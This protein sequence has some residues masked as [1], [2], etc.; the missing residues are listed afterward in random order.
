MDDI[1][2]FR[3]RLIETQTWCAA[4]IDMVH[5]DTSLRSPLLRPTGTHGDDE[6][7]TNITWGSL[8]ERR[9]MV[10]A[11]TSQRADLLAQAGQVPAPSLIPAI[12]G[13]HLAYDPDSTLSDGAAWVASKG[14]FDGDN[15][16][17]WDTWIA[18]I[19]T[20][21]PGNLFTLARFASFLVSWV[22]QDLVD[23][24]E[25]A[26]WANPEECIQW[27]SDIDIPFIHRLRAVGLLF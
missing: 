19:D 11:L 5:P 26:L 18:Y 2:E 22:P 25:Y 6:R 12:K 17:A 24:V 9:E 20:E 23:M 4:R 8:A 16:P 3:K 21:T 27:A 1:E 14:F 15:T 10:A 13:R 7:M